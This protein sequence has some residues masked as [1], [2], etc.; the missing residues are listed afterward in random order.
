M[1]VAQ[2]VEPCLGQTNYVKI[3]GTYIVIK[4]KLLGPETSNIL[5]LNAETVTEICT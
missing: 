1:T 2:V 5:I 3:R 4:L